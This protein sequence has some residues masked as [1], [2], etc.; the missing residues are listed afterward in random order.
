MRSAHALVALA[1]ACFLFYVNPVSGAQAVAPGKVSASVDPSEVTLTPGTAA[2]GVVIVA[3]DG[4]TPARVT[5]EPVV[6]D[7]LSIKVDISTERH[8]LPA[9]GSASHT[10]AVTRLAEGAGQDTGVRFLI[11][12]LQAPEPKKQRVSHVAVAALAVKAAKSPSLVEARIESNLQNINENRPGEAALILV[13][14]RET[15]V[16]VNEIAVT[17]PA[18]VEVT[19]VCAQTGDTETQEL[20]T[21]GGRTERLYNCPGHIA[22]RS[23]TVLHLDLATNDVVAPG[24]RLA[25]ISIEA[26]DDKGEASERVVATLAF[27]VDVFAESDILKAIG[28]PIFLL[29]PGVIVLL[30]AWFLITKASPWRRVSTGVK[31]EEVV[32]KATA[33]AVFGLAI[34]LV[35]AKIYP[36]LTL[37][38]KPGQER[39]YVKAYS[40]RDF[41][42][43]FGYSFAIAIL[44]WLVA[45]VIY[46]LGH[47]LFLVS[48]GD[49]AS[50]MLRKLGIR[51]IVSRRTSYGRVAIEGG[52]N[53]L[54]YGNRPGDKVL[55]LPAVT[56][57]RINYRRT[58]GLASAIESDV[59]HRRPFRLWLK[60]RDAT[61]N[62]VASV[63]F[64]AGDVTRPELIDR[65]KTNSTGQV[66]PIV[67]VP[68]RS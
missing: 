38:F 60:L 23:R 1:W 43:V 29:L 33:A 46:V 55:V 24:P 7:P 3:N 10:F 28:V 25:L 8:E 48:P 17:A 56:V 47:W 39:D 14:P 64:R 16:T 50:A 52:K 57:A 61:R 68:P 54:A 18:A 40:F 51:G 42:Y 13:N 2:T 20:L 63:G 30:T 15:P 66:G 31:F 49:D 12:Y 27:T 41:Y 67:E 58:P 11:K 44:V 35:I 32:S 5:I 4:T 22:G 45:V 9:G 26:S 34:S 6:G 53:G 59:R 65:T 62:E 21:A 37:H 36:W 19:L